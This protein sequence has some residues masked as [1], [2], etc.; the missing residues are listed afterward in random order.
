M[1]QYPEKALGIYEQN[2]QT[3]ETKTPKCSPLKKKKSLLN[4]VSFP[5]F[6]TIQVILH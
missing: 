1:G 3:E 4:A 6:Y 2:F 5:E